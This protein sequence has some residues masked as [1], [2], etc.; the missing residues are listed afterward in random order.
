MCAREID[1]TMEP[2]FRACVQGAWVE[3]DAW[4]DE[5]HKQG[6]GVQLDGERV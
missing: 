3:K 5:K 1:D 6:R 2:R 4:L